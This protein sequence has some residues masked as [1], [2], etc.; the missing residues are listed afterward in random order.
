MTLQR[1][2]ELSGVSV[3][4][5][6]KAFSGSRE[7]SEETRERIFCI[8]KEHDCFDKYYKA[9][10]K[11]PL[12]ALMV[13]EPE[14]E[15]YAKSIGVFERE[16]RERGADVII[17]F[18]RFEPEIEARMFRELA[19]GMKVD[20]VIMSGSG[21]LIRNPDELPLVTI[22]R[23]K[24][25]KNNA[26]TVGVEF[27]DGI[28]SL[29]Q[30]IKTYGH[31]EV[32]FIGEKLTVSKEVIFRDTLRSVGLAVRDENIA[33]V[34][35]RFEDAGERGM[36]ILLERGDLPSVIVAAY[37]RI[38]YGAI[39]YAKSQGYRVPDDISFVGMDDISSTSY[40]DIPLSSLHV[41]FDKACP[42]IV[43]LIFKRIKNRHYRSRTEIT[44]PVTVNIRESLKNVSDEMTE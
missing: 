25:P 20:G 38:A 1:L 28:Y 23:N 6:S 13:P 22:S 35:G 19:Y 8:A 26:D 14:S 5:V 9:P 30:T 42:E 24:N 10:R 41:D 15:Y 11:R 2:A 16:L 3:G 34:D 29:A 18:T 37:D 12:I 7:I 21:K 17:A 43:D 27:D 44:V 36:K 40:F 32:G 33:M 4:T 31:R 39:K